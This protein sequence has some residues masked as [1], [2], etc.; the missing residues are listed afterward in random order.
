MSD[1]KIKLNE[2]VDVLEKESNPKKKYDEDHFIKLINKAYMSDEMLKQNVIKSTF[3]SSKTEMKQDHMKDKLLSDSF[4]DNAHVSL[5]FFY[6]EVVIK[7]FYTLPL[8]MLLSATIVGVW[9]GFG[10]GIGKAQDPFGLHP[11]TNTVAFMG[12]VICFSVP[13][14]I[15]AI[16]FLPNLIINKRKNNTF[17]RM[18]LKGF[19]KKH[20][21]FFLFAWTSIALI[22][23]QMFIWQI[24]TPIFTFVIS[25]DMMEQHVV[26]VTDFSW[27][28]LL[29]QILISNSAYIFVG[30]IIGFVINNPK[31]FMSIFSVFI[32]L[33][34]AYI[35]L[36]GSGGFTESTFIELLTSESFMV[37]FFTFVVITLI[38]N[39]FNIIQHG[40]V[41]SIHDL[42]NFKPADG[43]WTNSSGNLTYAWWSS[44]TKSYYL[45]NQFITM[46]FN[47]SLISYVLY[48]REKIFNFS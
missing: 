9:G 28:F 7:I 2:L 8:L 21:M 6:R 10:L 29:T 3:D 37:K 42:S 39:P 35:W 1:K 14:I 20:L 24:W 41:L 11:Y 27:F 4:K 38:Y 36:V 16:G 15:I 45:T 46:I 34:I 19:N 33:I 17:S 18:R 30:M 44:T 43:M 32:A 13:S 22:A 23:T 40:L 5:V 31:V 12:M 26:N 47:A 25:N 48:D